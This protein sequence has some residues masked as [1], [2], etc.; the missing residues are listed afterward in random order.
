ML[1]AAIRAVEWEID[2]TLTRIVLAGH[3]RTLHNSIYFA[4]TFV[5]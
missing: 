3:A 5:Y 1:I 4:W 2:I